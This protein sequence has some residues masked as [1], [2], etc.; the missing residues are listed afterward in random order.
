MDGGIRT[1]ADDGPRVGGI[2]DSVSLHF[3]YIVAYYL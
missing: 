3:S 2:D 1:V